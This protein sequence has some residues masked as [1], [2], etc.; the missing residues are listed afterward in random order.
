MT[1]SRVS[2]LSPHQFLGHVIIPKSCPAEN[3]ASIAASD[4]CFT[5]SW[6]QF[7]LRHITHLFPTGLGVIQTRLIV[8]TLPDPAGSPSY[9]LT[10]VSDLPS[11]VAIWSPLYVIDILA[12]YESRYSALINGQCAEEF[13]VKEI[14]NGKSKELWVLQQCF[15][16]QRAR[17]SS[18]HLND[19]LEAE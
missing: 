14:A 8:S 17:S 9:V 16:L 1:E 10:I 4:A 19:R 5:L 2:V 13:L 18:T 15:N 7:T 11:C 3:V 12:F 6:W